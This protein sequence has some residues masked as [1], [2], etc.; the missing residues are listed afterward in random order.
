MG[1]LIWEG[2]QTSAGD[3][4]Q[5]MSILYGKNLKATQIDNQSAQLVKEIMESPGAKPPNWP[6]NTSE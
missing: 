6:K 2:W 3:A 5:P 1:K 4:P